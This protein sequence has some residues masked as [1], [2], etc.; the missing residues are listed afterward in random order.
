MSGRR[1]FAILYRDYLFRVVDPE[2]LSSKGTG[3]ASQLLLQIVS[4][5]L[6]VSVLL[7]I[8]ASGFQGEAAGLTLLGYGWTFEHFLIATTMLMVGVF[9]VLGWG[10]MF[11]DQRDVFVLAPLPVRPSTILSAKVAAIVTAVV[12]AI[13]VLHVVV[14]VVW[15]LLLNT[16]AR[17]LT[18]PALTALPALSYRSRRHRSGAPERPRSCSARRGSCA[19]GRW[20]RRRCHLATWAAPSVCRRCRQAALAVPGRVAD[21]AAHRTGAGA[22]GR[23]AQGLPGRAGPDA[24]PVARS[25][26]SDGARNHNQ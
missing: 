3:D 18:I 7:C 13:S 22:A 1:Q 21:Q 24:A 17:P 26:G 9:A 6:I 19:R 25:S 14:G 8:P 12:M 2:L 5:L 10:S 11:P 15:P 16:V 23:R 20:W 4:L